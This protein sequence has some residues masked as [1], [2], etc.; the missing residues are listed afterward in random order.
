MSIGSIF[1]DRGTAGD[2]NTCYDDGCY[3]VI[4]STLNMPIVYPG[5]GVVIVAN[6]ASAYTVQIY[7]ANTGAMYFRE[8]NNKDWR[9]WHKVS[10]SSV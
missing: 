4:G 7:A 9:N 6:A 3:A 1:K 2:L 8:S 10:T 5:W